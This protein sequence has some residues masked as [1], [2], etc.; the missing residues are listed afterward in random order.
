M[1][2]G[3]AST[4]FIRKLDVSTMRISA[5]VPFRVKKPVLSNVIG[6]YRHR[7]NLAKFEVFFAALRL[8]TNI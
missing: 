7:E 8:T 4:S 6:I 5:R 3:V 2:S 1:D